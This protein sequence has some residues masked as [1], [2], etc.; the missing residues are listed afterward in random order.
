MGIAVD[1]ADQK[2]HGGT[3]D[4]LRL[5][6]DAPGVFRP[7]VQCEPYD[8]RFCPGNPRG[9]NPLVGG[10]S[11][12]GSTRWL[13]VA[14]T[15]IREVKPSKNRTPSLSR[16]TSGVREGVKVASG[17][18][19]D[20]FV[21]SFQM[22]GITSWAPHRWFDPHSRADCSNQRV[23][24]LGRPP[25]PGRE[26]PYGNFGM[27]GETATGCGAETD[28]IR[29]QPPAGAPPAEGSAERGELVPRSLLGRWRHLHPQ[30]PERGGAVHEV[31]NFSDRSRPP[32]RRVFEAPVSTLD[33]T[34]SQRLDRSFLPGSRSKCGWCLDRLPFGR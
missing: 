20:E 28:H 2:F 24:P 16:W 34:P 15:Q 22:R 7:R 4:F 26:L 5:M 21:F 33:M 9:V 27:P 25:P 14:A 1:L 12:K 6:I 19:R 32:R 17:S 10:V 3:S 11:R 13:L 8:S 29:V 30:L 23:D 18:W 31:N